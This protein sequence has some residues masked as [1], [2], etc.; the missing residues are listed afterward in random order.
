MVKRKTKI[1]ISETLD[2]TPEISEISKSKHP[3]S[4]KRQGVKSTRKIVGSALKQQT[5]SGKLARKII[6]K[7]REIN[8]RRKRGKMK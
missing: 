7:E 5:G 2:N 8:S 3:K 6:S 4:G 1:S